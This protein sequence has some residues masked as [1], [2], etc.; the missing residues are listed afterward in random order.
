VPIHRGD[1]LATGK[2][3]TRSRSHSNWR[4]VIAVSQLRRKFNRCVPAS[5]RR[6]TGKS[7]AASLQGNSP[8]WNVAVK[9][10]NKVG[11]K[12]T[13]FWHKLFASTLSSLSS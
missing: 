2:Y 13:N 7:P 9:G 8:S 3:L 10:K 1:R 5:K 12:Q 6:E 11:R 4:K